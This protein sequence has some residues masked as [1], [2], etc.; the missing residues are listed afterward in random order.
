M[1]V[2]SF[3]DTCMFWR[4]Q[5]ATLALFL[6]PCFF[7]FL[8]ALANLGGLAGQPPPPGIFLFLPP[9]S[10]VTGTHWLVSSF[11]FSNYVLR[12]KLKS[13]FLN[14]VSV[15]FQWLKGGDEIFERSP[16]CCHLKVNDKALLQSCWEKCLFSE[17][18]LWTSFKTQE[19][20]QERFF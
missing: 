9:N 3:R 10:Q 11:Y 18:N 19:Y 14:L 17:V 12:M 8:L 15:N 13:S 1:C 6:P 4:D 7:L 5:R 20:V 2:C 16:C